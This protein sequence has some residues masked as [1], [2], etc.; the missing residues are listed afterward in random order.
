M[1]GRADT[2]EQKREVV[3]RLLRCWE[4]HPAARLGQLILNALPAHVEP[5]PYLYNVEDF[6]LIK[7]LENGKPKVLP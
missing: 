2:P 5:V 4:A 6:V 3:E 7:M 1:K